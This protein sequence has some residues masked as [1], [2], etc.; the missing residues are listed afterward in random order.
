MPFFICILYERTRRGAL[1]LSKYT[2]QDILNIIEEEDVRFIRLQFTDIFGQIRNI[3]VT[4]SQIEKAL[5]G[6]ILFDGSAIE[7]F[8]RVEESDMY[9]VPD[10]D[11]FVIFPWRPHQGQVARLICDM[12]KP[13]G[14]E[15][16][17]N[18]RC[19]LKKVLKEAEDL[20]YD[21]YVGPECEFFL[22]NTDENG[23]PTLETNDRGG[24]FDVAPIDNG[25]NCRRD[26]CLT[27][28]D[29]DYE[30]E[31]SHHEVAMGQNEID[32]KYGKAL[33]TADRIVTFKMVVKTIAKRHGMHATFM[34]KPIYGVNGSGMH[35]NMSLFKDGANAFYDADDPKKLSETAY[36]FMAGV[37]RYVREM[38]VLTNPIVNS[39]KRL[40]PGYE[41]PCYVAWSAGNR[42][43][44]MRI[45]SDGGEN[46]RIELRSPDPTANPYLAI[47]ACLK[48]GLTGI[49][50]KL[51]PPPSIDANLFNMKPKELE[52][53]G[54]QNM[55]ISL[56]EA[57][58]IAR[59]S[60]FVKELL[61][62]NLFEVYMEQKEREYEQ[63]RTKISPWELEEYLI[64]Y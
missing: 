48:A 50:E 61:G 29:M 58:G 22:F 40:I 15:F 49:K 26:I 63:Y 11:T 7:G 16:E 23:A 39:Y 12:R 10:L 13:S 53:L 9:L 51:V 3:A 56:R 34:P 20:G 4:Q 5:E 57:V 43:L 64:R 28:E 38:A 33:A 25:E 54:I 45:P 8:M 14:E 36:H 24:Y 52:T 31:S 44:L 55:P 30:I 37:L 17:S 59:R 27:L 21:F 41:A 42:S 18:P 32:F 60:D 46:T 62:E 47:A 19:I 35:I 6:R 2:K 1:K